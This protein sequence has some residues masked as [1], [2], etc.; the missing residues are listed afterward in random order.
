MITEAL[1]RKLVETGEGDI[2]VR[3]GT[4]ITPSAKDI[5][6]HAGRNLVFV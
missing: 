1:A 6:L 2:A 3:K 5:F 4:V